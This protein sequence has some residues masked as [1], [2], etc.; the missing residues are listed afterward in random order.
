MPQNKISV[1][2]L[3]KVLYH[4]I[5]NS[6]PFKIAYG[7]QFQSLNQPN[8]PIGDVLPLYTSNQK[9]F[10]KNLTDL[11]GKISLTMLTDFMMR[12]RLIPLGF[13]FSSESEASIFRKAI[14]QFQKEEQLK[15]SNLILLAAFPK[16]LVDSRQLRDLVRG[17]RIKDLGSNVFSKDNWEEIS[18]AIDG[19]SEDRALKQLKE[20]GS[21]VLELTNRLTKGDFY[22]N[23]QIELMEEVMIGLDQ[24]KKV[25][26]MVQS[27]DQRS[28]GIYS[29]SA[30]EYER[31]S[32][33][34]I[35]GLVV[36]LIV[37]I[38]IFVPK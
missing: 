37:L 36:F 17:Y 12:K 31:T 29:S 16:K 34:I 35:V 4:S 15:I 18:V 27:L 20:E 33:R 26:Q 14:F 8:A 11:R 28:K 7:T 1:Q 19:M 30:S 13:Y 25:E 32:K 10:E 9:V 3:R 2:I 21:K 6:N 24:N 22:E 38:I 5:L 23:H